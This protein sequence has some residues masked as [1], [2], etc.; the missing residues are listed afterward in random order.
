VA[1]AALVASFLPEVVGWAANRIEVRAVALVGSH[2]SGRARPDSD[3]DLVVLV[4]DP[5]RF[6]TGRAWLAGF[7]EVAA[8]EVEEWGAVT[9]LRTRYPGGLEVEW[10]LASP[11]W[12]KLDPVDPGTA[13]VVAN[14][15]VALYDPEGI[16]ARL[17]A[18]VRPGTKDR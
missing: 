7:G 17:M 2:A 18:A 13:R 10:G 14:G 1:E 11:D 6:I 12:A 5:T 3:V 15:L 16:L 4:A 8:V 9:S